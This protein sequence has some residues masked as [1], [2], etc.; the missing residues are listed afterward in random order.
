MEEIAVEAFNAN[1]ALEG[2][3][4]RWVGHTGLLLVI[5]IVP[6]IAFSALFCSLVVL[7]GFAVLGRIVASKTSTLFGIGDRSINLP[8]ISGAC[9]ALGFKFG[10]FANVA[11]AR[12]AHVL[13]GVQ[14]SIVEKLSEVRAILASVAAVLS[15]ALGATFTIVNNVVA[16]LEGVVILRNVGRHAIRSRRLRQ[17]SLTNFVVVIPE[18]A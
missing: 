2:L 12:S 3:A 11:H 14:I 7:A 17:A 15:S 18:R 9:L 13:G 5:E 8:V 6:V 16:V 1:A 4:S 10:G